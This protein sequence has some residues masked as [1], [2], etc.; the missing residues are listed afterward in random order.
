MNIARP[1]AFAFRILD[2][3]VQRGDCMGVGWEAGLWWKLELEKVSDRRTVLGTGS[4]L[5]RAKRE[6][7][8]RRGWGGMGK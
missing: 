4:G 6:Q 8:C 7:D 5:G 3:R 2:K 1:H